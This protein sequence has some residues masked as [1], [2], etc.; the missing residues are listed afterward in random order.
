LIQF[1]NV[2]KVYNKQHIA[3]QDVNLQIDQGEFV[4]LVGPSGAG[5]STLLRLLL[6]QELPTGGQILVAGRSIV[7]LA[8]REIPI[9]RRNMGVVFQDFKL[10]ENQTV[11]ENVALAL[12]VQGFGGK[13]LWQRV[14]RVLD[15]VGLT[16]KGRVLPTELSGGEQQRVAIARAVVNSPKILLAD[17]PTGNLD[18]VTSLE[19]VDLLNDINVRGTTIIMATHDREIVDRMHKRVV[20]LSQ[21]SVVLDKGTGGYDYAL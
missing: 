18:P 19:I 13:E 16:G 10:L 15:L 3:L 12:R 5:K 7:R 1:F 17:E 21:G 8:R 6:R 14:D 4:F 20:R 11:H 9:L 2:S